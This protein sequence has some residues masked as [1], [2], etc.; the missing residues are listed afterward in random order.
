MKFYKAMAGPTLT[1]E[2]E[3]WTITTTTTK[4]EANIETAEMK[5]LRNVAGCAGKDQI[6]NTKIMEELNIFSPNSKIL[7]SRS[8]WKYHVL[9]MENRRIPKKILAHNPKRLRNVGRPQS[10]WKDQ[11]SLQEDGTDQAWPSP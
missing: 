10:R 9:R 5:F 7:K 1:Y 3:I 6:G 2:S 8:Q 11:H 4:Q